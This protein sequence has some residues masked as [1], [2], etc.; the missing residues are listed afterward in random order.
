MDDK[1]SQ[2]GF[3]RFQSRQ[4]GG[5]PPTKGGFYDPD[6]LTRVPGV[7]GQMVDWMEESA[8]KPSRRFALGAA[9]AVGGTILGHTVLGVEEVATH[10]NIA[11]LGPTTRGKGHII[12]ASKKLL[13]SAGAVCRIGP[14]DFGSS[15]AFI[16][17]LTAQHGI[18]LSLIDE[19]GDVLHRMTKPS[20]GGWETDL[21]RTIKEIFSIAFE[22]YYPSRKA[23][24]KEYEPIVRRETGKE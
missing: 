6:D 18:F 11:L 9:L 16:E 23:R 5:Q 4:G 7:V 17:A 3:E 14:S 2:S 1:S 19:F 13:S 22:A 10:L 8:R 21:M 15:T 20:A 12:S 24:Q